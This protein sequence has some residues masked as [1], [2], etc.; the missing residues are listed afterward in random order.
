M[1][2]LRYSRLPKGHDC[3]V[4]NFTRIYKE[5][6]VEVSIDKSYFMF[7]RDNESPFGGEGARGYQ[8]T[9]I[10]GKWYE[11]RYNFVTINSGD[12]IFIS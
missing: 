9:F 2:F 5:R 4:V 7:E 1:D 3:R 8:K 10:N 11:K 12:S 6:T